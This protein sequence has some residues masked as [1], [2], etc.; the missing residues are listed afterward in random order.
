M[1]DELNQA[2][3]DA[4]NALLDNLSPEAFE[5]L[6][7]YVRKAV[8]DAAFAEIAYRHSIKQLLNQ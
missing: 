2:I 1:T 5:A 6:P 7:N 4:Y 8:E 3:Y